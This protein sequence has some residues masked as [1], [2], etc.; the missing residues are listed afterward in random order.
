MLRT[1]LEIGSHYVI[2]KA[3]FYRNENTEYFLNAVNATFND[4]AG[5]CIYGLSMHYI[6]HCTLHKE[7]INRAVWGFTMAS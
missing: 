3:D 2:K 7:Q 6:A 4:K 1:S 5:L